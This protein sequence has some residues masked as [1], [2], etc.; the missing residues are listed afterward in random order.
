MRE[1]ESRD[2]PFNEMV[3][4]RSCCVFIGDKEEEI[5]SSEGEEEELDQKG[6]RSKPKWTELEERKFNWLHKGWT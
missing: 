3:W 1:A 4:R 6:K 5:N 2:L